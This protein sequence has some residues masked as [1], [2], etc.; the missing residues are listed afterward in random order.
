MTAVPF[1]THRLHA[2]NHDS[3]SSRSVA[4]RRTSS[5]LSSMASVI[6][7]GLPEMSSGS[8]NVH[9]PAATERS[10]ASALAS[11][12]SAKVSRCGIGYPFV[13][14]RTSK[15]SDPALGTRELQTPAPCRVRCSAL[16]RRLNFFEAKKHI[17]APTRWSAPATRD[18]RSASVKA[19]SMNR[20]LAAPNQCEIQGLCNAPKCNGE[21]RLSR[22]RRPAQ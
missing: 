21:P 8:I 17:S 4:R 3:T 13:C 1:G 15:L 11:V 14:G 22:H 16:V 6:G 9:E 19:R 5:V 7:W 12:M 10:S 20:R 2:K 18:D